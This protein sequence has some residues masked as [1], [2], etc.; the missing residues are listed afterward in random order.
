MCHATFETSDSLAGT[1]QLLLP[2]MQVCQHR[3]MIRDSK[4]LYMPSDQDV[5]MLACLQIIPW[6]ACWLALHQAL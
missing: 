4:A 3:C 5:Y 2:A 6:R 1:K